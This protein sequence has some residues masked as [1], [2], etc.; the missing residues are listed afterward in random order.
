ME[1]QVKQEK[2]VNQKNSNKKQLN[3]QPNQN[4]NFYSSFNLINS[5]KRNNNR[6]DILYDTPRL[7][8]NQKRKLEQELDNLNFNDLDSD[9]E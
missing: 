7:T 3:N 8:E 1:K 9:A 6:D 2:Q 5:F 4:N